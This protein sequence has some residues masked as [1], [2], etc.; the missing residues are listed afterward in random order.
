VDFLF[1]KRPSRMA[2]QMQVDTQTMVILYRKPPNSLEDPEPE[3]PSS[4]QGSPTMSKGP[5]S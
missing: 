5:P 1:P 2:E 4:A 3:K